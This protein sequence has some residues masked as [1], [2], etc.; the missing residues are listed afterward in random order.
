MLT[1]PGSSV[2]TATVTRGVGSRYQSVFEELTGHTNG[3]GGGNK[4]NGQTKDDSLRSLP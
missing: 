2:V 4:E 3:T 1:E